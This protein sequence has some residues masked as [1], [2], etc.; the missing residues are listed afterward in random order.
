MYGLSV[1]LRNLATSEAGLLFRVLSFLLEARI[2][3]T[4]VREGQLNAIHDAGS[5]DIRN[6]NHRTHTQLLIVRLV[7]V[8]IHKA[9]L[10][11][12]MVP[13]LRER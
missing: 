3:R 7:I 4:E 11:K 6:P 9:K 12:N 8:R 10:R 2:L 13:F 5:F 1:I